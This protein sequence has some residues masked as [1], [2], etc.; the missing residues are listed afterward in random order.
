M[1]VYNLTINEETGLL[2]MSLVES[3]AVDVDFFAF[4][5][6]DE[7]PLYFANEE[8]RIVTGVAMRADYPI[9]RIGEEGGYYVVMSA[10]TIAKCVEK[11]M[12]EQRLAEVDIEH[13]GE[14]VAGV[15][16]IES[17]ILGNV[18][19][20]RFADVKAGSWIVSYKIENAEVWEKV[21][22]GELKGFS[23]EGYFLNNS[24]ESEFDKWIKSFIK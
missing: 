9:Y 3:P 15:Y 18:K 24:R 23:V 21:K 5:K 4:K 13:N 17:Y 14:K 8:K 20:E 10:D 11:F 1:Q 7:K 19:D 2:C 16:M 12:K 6:E 22:R